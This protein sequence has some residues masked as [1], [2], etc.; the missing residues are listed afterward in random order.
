MSVVRAVNA[1]CCFNLGWKTRVTNVFIIL[2]L[3]HGLLQNRTLRYT[4]HTA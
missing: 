3:S 1:D 4:V 2:L